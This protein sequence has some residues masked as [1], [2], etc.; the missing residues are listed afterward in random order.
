MKIWL[1][2]TLLSIFIVLTGCEKKFVPFLEKGREDFSSKNFIN[3]VDNLN[4]GLLHWKE[5][6]GSDRKAEAYELLGQAYQQLRNTDKAIESYQ[7]A[8][9]LSTSTFLSAYALG[10]IY[11]TK[12]QSEAAIVNF[13]KALTMKK[14]DP[15]SLLGLANGFYIG[16][17]YSDAMATY[18]KVLD[19]SPGVHDALESLTAL[20]NRGRLKQTFS[21]CVKRRPP[22]KRR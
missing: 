20:R 21:L 6:D 18:Q 2:W 3:C 5:S 13:R 8:V 19:V 10:M 15:L 4:V 1:Q 16:R 14:D 17:R 11:L 12:E 9:K 7:E 22:T